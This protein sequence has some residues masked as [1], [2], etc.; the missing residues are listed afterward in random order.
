[1]RDNRYTTPAIQVG[2]HTGQLGEIAI[3]GVAFSG[4]AQ[5]KRGAAINSTVITTMVGRKPVVIG[6]GGFYA[7]RTTH[8]SPPP[9]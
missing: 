7:P 4:A 9:P 3:N 5:A 1:M 6:V 2:N 8:P